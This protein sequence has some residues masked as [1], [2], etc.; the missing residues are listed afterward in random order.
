MAIMESEND[1]SDL[2]TIVIAGLTL[3]LMLPFVT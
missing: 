3:V 1:T 2:S